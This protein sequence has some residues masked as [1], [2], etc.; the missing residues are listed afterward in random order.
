MS[1]SESI[2]GAG[3]FGALPDAH[4]LEACRKAV[5]EGERLPAGLVKWL[6][7]AGAAFLVAFLLVLGML[8]WGLMSIR[9]PQIFTLL[10]APRPAVAKMVVAPATAAPA[11]GVP[12]AQPKTP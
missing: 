1:L 4:L 11:A 10:A 3:K 6:V 7:A 2:P 12:A 9:G 8:V 5:A